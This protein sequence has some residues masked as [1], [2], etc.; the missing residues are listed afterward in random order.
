VKV[1]YLADNSDLAN[2]GCRATSTALREMILERHEIIGTVGGRMIE[3][4][5]PVSN[6]VADGVWGRFSR[7][8]NRSRVRALPLASTTFDAFGRRNG[9]SHDLDANIHVLRRARAYDRSIRN[10]FAALEGADCVV[11]NGEGD[12]IFS[13]PAR[14]R[15]LFTLTVCEMALRA[16]KPLFYLNAMVSACPLSGINRETSAL[17]AGVL[18]RAAAFAVRDPV[19]LAFVRQE[20]PGVQ[21][22][23]FPDAV[24]SWSARYAP[25]TA[26]DHDFAPIAAAFADIGLRAPKVLERPYVILGG[27][28]RAARNWALATERY[29]A[30]AEAVQTLGLPVVLAPGCDGDLFL[31]RVARQTGAPMLPLHTPISVVA[32]VLSGARLMISGRWHPSILASLGG[33]PTV[34]MGSNSHKTLTIQSMLEQAD[35]REFDATP[36]SAEIDGILSRARRLLDMGDGERL[37]ILEV[38]DRLS[39][40]ARR[41]T[42]LVDSALPEHAAVAV[43]G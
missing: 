28:S 20:M 36:S 1:L 13:T 7:T 21:V 2:W 8:F 14:D 41:S 3:A 27:G 23:M 5:Y 17:A 38:V 12:L 25:P 40:A 9:L 15:L 4:Q 29:C 30:L 19:S 6:V 22:E 11:V 34:F 31:E 39:K 18:G 16:G 33:V 35:P 42:S 24:F 37:R 26:T 10:M 32:A 43:A